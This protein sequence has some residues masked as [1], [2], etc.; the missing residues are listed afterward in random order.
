MIRVGK[1]RVADFLSCKNEGA[2]SETSKIQVW[3]KKRR[4]LLWNKQQPVEFLGSGCCRNKA[5]VGR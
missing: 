2:T 3:N 1:N 4:W 5:E